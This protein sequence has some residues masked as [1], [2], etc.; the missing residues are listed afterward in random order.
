MVAISVRAGIER[1]ALAQ[2]AAQVFER[3]TAQHRD[4]RDGNPP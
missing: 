1:H 2:G 3:K 4:A